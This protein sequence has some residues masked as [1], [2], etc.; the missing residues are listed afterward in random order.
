M[1]AWPVAGHHCLF[2]GCKKNAV[3]SLHSFAGKTVQGTVD[4]QSPVTR[5]Y[6]VTHLKSFPQFA[7][8]TIAVHQHLRNG[9]M[10]NHP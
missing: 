1:G 8:T 4:F 7:V 10:K 2:F 5:I 9:I 3:F 6:D